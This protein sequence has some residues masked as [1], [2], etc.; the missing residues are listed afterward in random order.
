MS[1]L[2]S[3]ADEGS[4]ADMNGGNPHIKGSPAYDNYQLGIQT[5]NRDIS[6]MERFTGH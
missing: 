2:F 5:F 3:S 1:Y 4:V 6:E